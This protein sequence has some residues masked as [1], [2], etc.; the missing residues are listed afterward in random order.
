MIGAGQS[1]KEIAFALSLSPKTVDVMLDGPDTSIAAKLGIKGQG[2]H[3]LSKFA[4][5][6]GLAADNQAAA[7]KPAPMQVTDM[8][9]MIQALCR[10][11]TLAANH[12]S[13]VGHTTNLCKCALAYAKLEQ[14][15]SFWGLARKSK[16]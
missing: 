9:T 3:G 13:D 2:R 10:G 12:E 16:T 7:P 11:A 1:N 4:F 8:D 14:I 5:K 15:R 6:H